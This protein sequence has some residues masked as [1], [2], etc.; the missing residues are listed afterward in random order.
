MGFY[1]CQYLF[2][3]NFKNFNLAYTMLPEGNKWKASVKDVDLNP[4]DQGKDIAEMYKARTTIEEKED[5]NGSY[6]NC[7]L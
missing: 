4:E 6:K 7:K 3:K 2:E 1:T 5:E